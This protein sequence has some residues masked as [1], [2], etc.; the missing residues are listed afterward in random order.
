[1]RRCS[2]T[3]ITRPLIPPTYDSDPMNL[4]RTARRHSSGFTLVEML[5]TVTVAAILMAIAVPS[6]TRLGTNSRLS[7]Q[8]NELISLISF[9]RSEA[10]TKNSG[11]VLCRAATDVA[12]ACAGSTEDWEFWIIRNAAGEVVR[13]G[14]INTFG[15]TLVVN[16]TL[17]ADSVT[18]GSDGLSRTGGNL[19]N[20]DDDD[21]HSFRICSTR[22]SSDN[23]RQVLMGASSR[24]TTTTESGTC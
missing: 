15:G 9:T 24:V 22:Q 12:T 3:F 14:S 11:L 19:V 17:A 5:I 6:F 1:M 20:A 2:V 7:S 18:F 13:R 16:S 4:Q 10:I 8:A 21:A 23:I